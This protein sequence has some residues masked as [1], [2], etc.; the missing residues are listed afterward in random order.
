MGFFFAAVAVVVD[1][2]SFRW[3][4]V[5]RPCEELHHSAHTFCS[6]TCSR[7]VLHS[8]HIPAVKSYITLLIYLQLHMCIVAVIITVSLSFSSHIHTCKHVTLLT[9]AFEKYTYRS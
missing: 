4:R 9:H 8:A 1:T 6:Y 5:S 3:K 7:E 2:I